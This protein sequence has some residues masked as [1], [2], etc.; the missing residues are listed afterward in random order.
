MVI[1]ATAVLSGGVGA[2]PGL[3]AGAPPAEPCNTG[4]AYA[5]AA[6]TGAVD[7][8]NCVDG[9]VAEGAPSCLA[10]GFPDALELN[11]SPS[12]NA[13]DAYVKGTLVGDDEYLDITAQ[14]GVTV[15]GAVIKGANDANLYWG[16]LEGLHS[17]AKNEALP[18]ISH[19][20]ICYEVEEIPEPDDAVVWV[21]K[22]FEGPAD[23]DFGFAF[24]CEN[25]DGSEYFTLGG[26]DSAHF[27]VGFDFD[28]QVR[29][30]TDDYEHYLLCGVL[31]EA[32]QGDWTVNVTVKGSEKHEVG[33]EGGTL[34]LFKVLPGDEISV[35]FENIPGYLAKPPTGKVEFPG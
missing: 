27:E 30:L 20:T 26:G 10:L 4:V 33:E 16:D 21:M 13:S 7:D 23:W 18:A 19:W 31:E 6:Y 12:A 3:D 5:N 24:A 34:A 9:N 29:E 11:R 17:P 1:A 14:P 15:L 28:P 35:T 8:P 32:L 25:S 22:K 2:V